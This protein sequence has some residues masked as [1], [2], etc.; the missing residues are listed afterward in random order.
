LT[1]PLPRRHNRPSSLLFFF[2]SPPL[3]CDGHFL[4]FVMHHSR[5]RFSSLFPP[6]SESSFFL[7]FFLLCPVCITPSK[8]RKAW[9]SFPSFLRLVCRGEISPPTL[10]LFLL[11]FSSYCHLMRT[12]F[13]PC[14]PYFHPLSLSFRIPRINRLFPHFLLLFSPFLFCG[15][16][17][18]ENQVFPPPFPLLLAPDGVNVSDLFSTPFPLQHDLIRPSSPL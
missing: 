14:S 3:D 11:L 9:K 12:I 4:F 6:L 10:P 2:F 5:L 7:S 13:F 17:I 18:L 16:Q 15:F 1:P 8:I